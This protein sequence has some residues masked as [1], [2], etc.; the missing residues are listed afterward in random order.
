MIAAH[1]G[2]CAGVKKAMEIAFQAAREAQQKGIPCHCLG[3]MI[4]NPQATGKLH[5]MGVI[6]VSDVQQAKGGIILL[7]SHGVAPEVYDACA[8]RGLDVRDGT[9]AYVKALHQI[10]AQSRLPVLLIGEKEHP[11]V[12]ATAG[13]C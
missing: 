4:H 3:E 8:A 7:R 2:Y 9:C 6:Q 11:E 10:V 13:W 1:A 5:E 12:Q